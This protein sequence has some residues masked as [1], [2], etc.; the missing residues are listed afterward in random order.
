M[1]I[2][3]FA[4]HFL[5]QS[6]ME[7]IAAGVI[8]LTRYKEYLVSVTVTTLL[9][10]LTAGVHLSSA[11]S[12][13]IL[14]VLLANFLSFAF[15]FMINDAEDYL[16]DKKD[17]LKAVRNPVSTGAIS[18][19]TA[20]IFSF[21]TA[22]AALYLYSLLGIVPFLLGIFAI[23]IGFLYSYRPVRLKSILFID[24][25]SHGLMLGGL[26][27]LI[28]YFTVY[29][30]KGFSLSW[31][32]PFLFITAVSLRGQLVN[33]VRDYECDRRA[34]INNVVSVIGIRKAKTLMSIFLSV[35][36]LAF[37]I[38]VAIGTIPLWVLL[39]LLLSCTTITV[40]SLITSKRKNAYEVTLRTQDPIL[41]AVLS[42]FLLWSF[43][44]FL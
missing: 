13:R 41:Y 1:K 31:A 25:V 39:L 5:L 38:S 16:D 44:R 40:Y 3:F 10:F 37:I 21:L 22:L 33:Q 27:T 4:L 8:S 32:L 24:L 29:S 30:F 18:L 2:L 28:A 9:G 35:S 6:T 42:V 15:T 36:L 23:A 11:D 19:K 20:Y 17:K 12:F 43:T 14:T 26:Q 34:K 7:K